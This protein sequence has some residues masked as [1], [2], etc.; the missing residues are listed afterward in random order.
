M[1]D[2]RAKLEQRADELNAAAWLAADTAAGADRAFTD[3]AAEPAGD[4]DPVTRLVV[5]GTLRP[6]GAN[7]HLLAGLEP[8]AS[9]S[10][11]SGG[12]APQGGWQP[13]RLRGWMGDWHGYPIFTPAAAGS[14]DRAAFVDAD[15]LTSAEL[16]R[17]YA[18][19]DAFE[20]PAYRRA[21]V[22]AETAS[23]LVLATCYVARTPRR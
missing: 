18:Q 9:A 5:Y 7:H 17:H 8:E 12:G 10:G 1:D 16:P 19:L 23:G 13:V 14:D 4:D 15:L 21:V 2:E 11:P 22:V 6:G 20:G 3:R